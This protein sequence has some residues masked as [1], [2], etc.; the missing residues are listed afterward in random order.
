M[1]AAVIKT[2]NEANAQ[3]RSILSDITNSTKTGENNE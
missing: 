3:K 1:R 2:V